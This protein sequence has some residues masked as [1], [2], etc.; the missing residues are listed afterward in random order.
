MLTAAEVLEQIRA[1]V[2]YCDD[3]PDNEITAD[4]PVRDDS[5]LVDVDGPEGESIET[6]RVTVERVV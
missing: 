4:E 2:R 6:W 1:S 3:M 5:L